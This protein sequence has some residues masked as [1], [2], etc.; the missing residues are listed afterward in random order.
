MNV[1][2]AD[3]CGSGSIWSNAITLERNTDLLTMRDLYIIES[4][5]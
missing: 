3:R 1:I 2:C 4:R 5:F